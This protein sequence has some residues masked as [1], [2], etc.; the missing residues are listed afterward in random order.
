[1]ADMQWTYRGIDFVCDETKQALNKRRHGIDM[2]EACTTF[3]DPCGVSIYD[4]EHSR[5]EDR[6]RITGM[7]AGGEILIVAYTMRNGAMRLISARKAEKWEE[8]E[9][10]ENIYK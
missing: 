2:L 6:H 1:M 5:E 7:S 10:E 9:Y 8:R 3:F 4:Q